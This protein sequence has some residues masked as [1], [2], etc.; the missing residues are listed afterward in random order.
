LTVLS[1]T[2]KGCSGS[3]VAQ[4]DIAPRERSSESS[5]FEEA[6]SLIERKL[7]LE[8]LTQSTLV[9]HGAVFSFRLQDRVGQLLT[10]FQIDGGSCHSERPAGSAA[11]AP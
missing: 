9:A 8:P 7:C 5:L 2:P 6:R 11:H 10:E 3:F 1:L 4:F